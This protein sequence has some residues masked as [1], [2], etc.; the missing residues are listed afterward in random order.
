MP[1]FQLTRTLAFPPPE[2]AEPD[3]LLAVGG[4]L[5]EGR[6][7]LAYS[8]G[9][10]PWYSEGYP[11]LWW[12]PSPRLVLIPGE[13]KMSRSLRQVVRK[14][15]FT[16]T[17]D[18]AFEQVIGSCAEISRKREKGTWIT[19]A[20]R[21]AYIRLHRSG[22][23]H[24]VE[25]WHGGELAG[26]LY[27]I[28]L[29]SAFFGESMFALKS[30]ASKVALSALVQYLADRGCTLIDCQVTTDHLLSLGAREVPRP[31]FQRML[32]KALAAPTRRGKWESPGSAGNH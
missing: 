9:I 17:M 29:G 12:S 21:E 23:A 20:M 2:L 14:G 3:G 31:E 6:L 15:V 27:G 24:S 28:S 7:L 16:V 22:Y 4:D 5:S 10:F 1:L 25:S 18:T 26:G 32:K 11:L 30:N 13:L 19:D 8:M